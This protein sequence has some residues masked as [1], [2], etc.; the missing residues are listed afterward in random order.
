M[1]VSYQHPAGNSEYCLFN[2]M[3][4]NGNKTV[5]GDLNRS[6]DSGMSRTFGP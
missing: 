4:C 1:A 3:L 2:K 5:T 6:T